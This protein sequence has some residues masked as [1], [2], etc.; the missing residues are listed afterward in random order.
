M[1]A[2]SPRPR[3][4]K[5]AVVPYQPSGVDTGFNVADSLGVGISPGGP[6]S[7][8][9]NSQPGFKS[10]IDVIKGL[11]ARKRKPKGT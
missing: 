5:R 3:P 6:N 9:A 8:Y 10:P 4:K 1:G 11:F 7:G 2:F